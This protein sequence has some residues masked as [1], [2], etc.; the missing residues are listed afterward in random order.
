MSKLAR[1]G[2]IRLGDKTSGGGIVISASGTTVKFHGRPTVLMGDKATC[3]THGG[4]QIFTE[5]CIGRKV[6]GVGIVLQGHRLTCGCTAI[7]SCA[8]TCWIE[9]C[10]PASERSSGA[11]WSGV[12]AG[13]ALASPAVGN[14]AKDA[15]VN[16]MAKHPYDRTFVITNNQTGEPLPATR[17]RLTLD[18]GQV[19]E[20]NTDEHGMTQRVSANERQNVKIEVFV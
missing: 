1:G 5:G 13:Q 16:D 20:G 3:Q 4:V 11:G 7:S 9:D 6:H 17:Y 18:N 2:P 8:D 19:V 14:A 15:V 10:S 12:S